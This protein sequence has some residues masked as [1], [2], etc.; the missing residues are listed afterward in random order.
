VAYARAG[1]EPRKLTTISYAVLGLLG[2][3]PHSAYEL[4][5]QNSR[6]G[7]F[8]SAAQSVVYEEAK[9]LAAQELATATTVTD[10]PRRR[11]VYAIT[12][13]GRRDLHRWLS[14]PGGDP[15][16]QYP[17][18]LR[19]L[20]AD[21]GTNADLLAAISSIRGWA[22][23]SR[24]NA[25]RIALDYLAGQPPPYPGRTH[26]VKLTMAYQMSVVTAVERWAD[27]AEAEARTWN[28]TATPAEADL[29]TFRRI[30]QG[31]APPQQPAGSPGDA[32]LQGTAGWQAQRAP[33][34]VRVL[35]ARGSGPALGDDG[36]DRQPEPALGPV[37]QVGPQPV[38]DGPGQ[39][40]YDDLVEL[41]IGEGL[42]HGLHRLGTAQV[43]FDGDTQR[44]QVSQHLAEPLPGL[45]ARLLIGGGASVVRHPPCHAGLQDTCRGGH[46]RIVCRSGVRDEQVE[47]A[48]SRLD[49]LA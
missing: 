31:W 49:P 7:I 29:E 37:G 22:R 19:V 3:R 14:E 2:I 9:K 36:R 44:T 11:T 23:R 17:D 21:A 34:D 18:M 46:V 47:R 26:I 28:D 27:W 43:T 32:S 20:F 25:Q 16:V 12:E 38:R 24:H 33:V 4:A 39:R 6:S 48:R 42:L 40:G 10:G 5:Q 41:V 45:R 13:A 8:W 35:A 30:L 1:K 15:Q